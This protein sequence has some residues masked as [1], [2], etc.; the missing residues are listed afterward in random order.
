MTTTALRDEA[1]GLRG[2]AKITRDMTERR[3]VE[4]KIESLALF[5][6]ENPY[7]VLRIA[8]DGPILHANPAALALFRD[9]NCEAGSVTQLLETAVRDAFRSAAIREI[10]ISCA[11]GRLF[12]FICTPLP[13][14]HYV[15]LYGSDITEKKKAT[16]AVRRS[17]HRLAGIID[18]AMDAIISV[19]ATQRIVLFNAAAEKMFRCPAAEAVGQPLERF[20]PERFRA[21]H[22]R[23]IR[24][25]GEEGT[26]SRTMGRLGSLMAL[27]A[28]GEE[29]PMEALISQ[30][31][32]GDQKL[33]TVI[34]RDITE[35]KRAE[36]ALQRAKKAAETANEAK[37]RFLTNISHE[38]HTPMNAVL[39]MVD[40]AIPKQVDPTT[41]DFS[42]TAKQSADLL[43]VLLNDLLDCAKIE[44]GKLQLEAR[45]FGLRDV[46]DQ[47][48]RVLTVRAREKGIG[49][50]CRVSPDVPDGL[51]GDRVRLQQ[52]LLNLGG[53]GV[54]FTQRGEVA[55]TVSAAS[56]DAA[57]VN[58]EFAVRDTG[59]G[60]TPADL[61]QLFRPFTQAD[62]SMTRRFGGTGVG[63][64][65]ASSLVGMMGGRIAVESEPGQ[66]STFHFTIRLPLA[67][68]PIS[69][70]E[71]PSVSLAATST[72]RILVV[73]D[74][75]A[76]QKLAAFIL[77]ERGHMVDIAENG[78]HGLDMA[79]RNQYDVIMMDV[80]MPLMDGLEATKAIR[81][82]EDGRCRVPIIAVTAH[83]MEEDRQRCLAA[84][85][86]GYLSK[87]IDAQEMFTLMDC[88]ASRQVRP[89]QGLR[90][91]RRLRLCLCSILPWP[92]SS[93]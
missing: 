35:R 65:I 42:R 72:L 15:N 49:Y 83:A 85:M 2:F 23:H 55:V 26:T 1:G 57:Q 33:F 69:E 76:N 14:K 8:T 74:N 53:N 31:E 89:L 40:L 59:I 71:F 51:F 54:K 92:S 47:I 68:E 82:W 24:A 45:P 37:T 77:K 60:I 52:V 22:A 81:A 29:F 91:S 56:Q 61:E 19:D 75:P 4:E 63:L 50:S 10:E 7:P 87:P 16:E 64:L 32:V 34:L 6:Q 27:R 78:R 5:P 9:A 79:Q 43:L 18:S 39:G 70:R 88:L 67:K 66:G 62:A 73:E 28:D 20:I 48:T 58:L 25:F 36:E 90:R 21:I 84:G 86:D 12:S 11:D 93:V 46:L 3:A 80:Q 30:I 13:E 17:E 44:S 41:A 38:L